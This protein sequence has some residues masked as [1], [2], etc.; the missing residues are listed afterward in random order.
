MTAALKYGS[1][2]Y[3]AL[4]LLLAKWLRHE[5]T[6][7]PYEYVTL[8]GTELVDV[9][10]LDWIDRKL[11]VRVRSYEQDPERFI[12]AEKT[13]SRLREQG[14]EIEVFADDLFSYNRKSDLPHIF[15]LDLFKIFRPVAYQK[16]LADWFDNLVIRPGDFLII[17]SYLGKRTPWDKVLSPFE[18]E[19]SF[20]NIA[21]KEKKQI[22]Y[23]TYHPAMVLYRAM[24]QFRIDEEIKIKPL[25]HIKYFDTSNMGLYGILC[26]EGR[27]VLKE[28][29]SGSYDVDLTR[30]AKLRFKLP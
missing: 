12:L 22:L 3:S 30:S 26:Q 15:Y 6:P 29:V 16:E 10:N 27:S 2:K 1:N 11:A 13:A 5:A 20:L 21:S 18:S 9:T 23:N 7:G 17:T 28:I 14:V 19:F 25:C 4:N 24:L 8:G